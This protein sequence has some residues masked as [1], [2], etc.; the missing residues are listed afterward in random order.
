MQNTLLEMDYFSS[1]NLRDD[2]KR[3]KIANLIV[4]MNCQNEAQYQNAKTLVGKYSNAPVV[5]FKSQIDLPKFKKIAVLT[6]IANP[7]RFLDLLRKDGIEIVLLKTL[8]DHSA[9]KNKMI[10]DFT[11]LAIN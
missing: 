8:R 10:D 2:P 4:L 6:A 9:L 7:N 5:G 3:L 11:D 1:W